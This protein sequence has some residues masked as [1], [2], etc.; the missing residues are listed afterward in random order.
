VTSGMGQSRQNPTFRGMSALAPTAT[1]ESRFQTDV[2]C[3][4]TEVRSGS[5]LEAVDRADRRNLMPA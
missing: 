2:Q 4:R 1:F 3:P 5:W